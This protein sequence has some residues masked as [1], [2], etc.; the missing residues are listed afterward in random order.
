MSYAHE[1]P[2][3]A[4]RRRWVIIATAVV[5]LV[6]A[7]VVAVATRV[8][9]TS[10]RLRAKVVSTLEDRLDSDVELDDLTLR[11]FPR[12]HAEGTGL[13][14]RHRGR[15]DVPPLVSVEKFAVDADL[16]GIWRRHVA[17]LKLEGLNIQIP[18]GDDDDDESDQSD[19]EKK[20]A[21][22]V[23]PAPNTNE[24]LVRP[25][26]TD[27]SDQDIRR[28]VVVDDFEAPDA[29]LTILRRDK[30]K[31]PRT[32][33]LH[34]LQ[35]RSVGIQAAMPFEALLTNAVPPGQ[36]NTRGTF[37]PWNRR[38][39][40]ITPL[41][42]TFTFD[43]ANLG[44]FG[45][46]SG[47]LSAHGTYSGSLA[48]IAVDGETDTPDF[49]VTISGHPLPLKT[50][51]HA[52]VDATTGNTTLD[53]VH[54]TFLNTSL[55]AKGG[56]YE[57]D[58]RDG[59]EVRLDVTMD[60]GRLEDIMRMS[61]KTPEPPMIGVLHLATKLILP[62]GKIDV[63]EKLQL[64]GRFAILKGR[65]TDRGVQDKINNLSGLA[66]GKQLPDGKAGI[67][68]VT[69]DFTG[70]FSLANGVLSLPIVTFDVP[71]AIVEMKGQYGMRGET[72]DFAGNLFMDAKISDTVTGWKSFIAKLAD[73]LFRKNGKT[74]IPL[75]VHGSRSA[76]EFG[77]DVKKALTRNT[78][79][80]PAADIKRRD[81]K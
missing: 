65:F 76:P 28:Q 47:I 25:A 20:N 8:P 71:G 10:E 18:P 3:S 55:V 13:I 72:I 2:V 42:G 66:S 33:Y 70:Q 9:F 56:V 44:V 23:G 39:P 73:P 48:R 53:P 52:L 54:A 74:V 63:I 26:A 14:V 67:T 68:G 49:M 37:G 45:G 35:M 11:I 50:K 41:D 32:W 40:G 15:T 75:K 7:V 17:H 69:S 58:D 61:V 1:P 16:I 60:D 4:V 59:R 62:P 22:S 6:A 79:E 30:T 19:L 78:P 38:N 5:V 81:T 77:V 27:E 51:Y 24:R 46:I 12:L 36:I 21:E 29:K 31:V 43:N 57:L 34:K 80:T 64:D